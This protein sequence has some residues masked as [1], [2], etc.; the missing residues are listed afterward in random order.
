MDRSVIAGAVRTPIGSFQGGLSSLKS[1]QLGSIVIREALSRA[2]IQPV[3]VNEVVMGCVLAAGL[4]QNPA[5]QAAIGAGIP[6]EVGAVTVNKVCSSG[7]YAVMMAD[8]LIRTG[9][10]DVVVAGGME[11]MS[12]A[13]YL[14]PEARGGLRMGDK[15]VVDSM[16]VDGLWD[17]FTDQHMGCCAE[18]LAEKYD[19]TREMQDAF[20]ESSYRKAL[21]AIESGAFKEEIVAVSVPQKKGEPV[22]FDTDEEPARVKFEKI[23]R[24]KASF[25]N[26]GTVT[27]ANASSISDGAAALVIMSEKRAKKEGVRPLATIVAHATHSQE[28]EWFTTAPIGAAR[29]ALQEAGLDVGDIDLFEINEAFSGV[30]LAAIK[31]LNIDESK[32][33]IH[34]G[35]VALGHP[36]GASGARIL[37]T[38]LYALKQRGGRR[39]LAVLCNG[40]GEATSIIVDRS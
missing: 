40:G 38:L 34:G 4:G 13:P 33:N 35:A 8:M 10:R 6:V 23:P 15:R 7:L 1:T 14:L 22:I 19:F 30:T 28:P 32:V 12:G 18:L 24:L 36:I 2:D 25:K 20:A 9:R 21:S 31:T 11:S 39:G 3:K 37:V 26:Q 5:R 27:A 29:Q 17:A 16:I